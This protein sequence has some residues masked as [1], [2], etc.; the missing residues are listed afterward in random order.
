MLSF[1]FASVVCGSFRPISSDTRYSLASR[2]RALM[3]TNIVTCST[4]EHYPFATS[5]AHGGRKLETQ[6]DHPKTLVRLG[7]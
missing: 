3:Y 6:R 1:S 7:T 5:S 4:G 2:L